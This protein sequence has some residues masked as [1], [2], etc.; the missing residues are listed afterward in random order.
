MLFTFKFL[1]VSD[2]HCLNEC[3]NIELK[4]GDKLCYTI[5]LYRSLSQSQ[6][7]FEQFS[8]TLELNVDTLV[9]KN[10]ILVALI[11]DFNVKS[12]N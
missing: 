9:R 10:P 5:V 3:N 1:R 8:E 6:D 2:I 11:G 4:I 12:K 7:E